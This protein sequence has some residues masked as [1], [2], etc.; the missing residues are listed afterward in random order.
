[1]NVQEWIMYKDQML[2][3]INV[4]TILVKHPKYRNFALKMP[5]FKLIKDWAQQYFLPVWVK[6]W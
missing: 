4:I 1:M 6:T 2:K 3:K 5:I